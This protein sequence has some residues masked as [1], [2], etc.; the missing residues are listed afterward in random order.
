MDESQHIRSARQ[1][2]LARQRRRSRQPMA[3]RKSDAQIEDQPNR[4]WLDRL[5][6]AIN[7]IR[8]H[9]KGAQIV[10]IPLLV[11]MLLFIFT[12][13]FSGRIPPN[14]F[15]LGT[16]I[17]GIPFDDAVE[18][19]ETVWAQDTS[20]TLT[21][22]TQ[23]WMVS[24]TQLGI[25]LDARASVEAANAVGLTGIPFGYNAAPVIS[26]NRDRLRL[27][28]Q[29]I[30]KDVYEAHV[31]AR[32]EWRNGTVSGVPGRNGVELNVDATVERVDQLLE[33][34]FQNELSLVTSVLSPSA[35]DPNLFLDDARRFIAAPFEL[36]V[37]DPF[38]DYSVNFTA[39]PETL[40][41]WIEAGENH[42]VVQPD[43]L[44]EYIETVNATSDVGLPENAYLD[45][46][47]VIEA[48][49][50]ALSEKS[51]SAQVVIRSR[52]TTYQV[53]AGDTG[54][55]ISRK[56]GIPFFLIEEA[57]SGRDL[58]VLSPGDVIAL[59]SRDV[60]LPL[61]VVADKRILV[62]L[63]TQSLAAY[64]NGQLVF[65]WRISSG[66]SE[67]PTSPGVYQILSH[68]SVAYGSSYTLCGDAGCGQWELNW[69]MGIYEVVPG[70]VN[71]F[72]GA[73]LLPNGS[74]LG[75]NNVG[76][77]YTLGC[78]MS[79]DDQARQLYE[80]AEEG[81]IVEIISADYPPQSALARRAFNY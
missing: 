34:G 38:A 66:I 78:V 44:S 69:F 39:A 15:I 29:G 33:A 50:A 75:G 62:N 32:Y 24:P 77:P 68:E 46:G 63:E 51:T 6:A 54:Y 21:A 36:R 14:V 71:G 64:E 3:V 52:P 59:P 20:L 76:T 28:L 4:V 58:S 70:L 17:G 49:N 23:E 45:A 1:R 35:G 81:T 67:A 30:S 37:Y 55:G 48:V 31:N 47:E 16:A 53:V 27:Y 12:V 40:S 56:T 5:K 60:T 74:Y 2:Q 42:L 26:V 19:L 10:G 65:D 22:G 41:T 9:R 61:P 8:Q 7:L 73:V 13:F 72:H 43:S 57:N 80:W 18:Q 11:L 25:Q 79:R